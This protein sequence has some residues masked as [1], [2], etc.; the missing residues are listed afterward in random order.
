MSTSVRLSAA[1]LAD[2][3]RAHDPRISVVIATCNRADSLLRTLQMLRK[4]PERPPVIVVDNASSDGAAAKVAQSFPEVRVLALPSNIGAAARNAGCREATTPYVAFCDDDSWWSPGSLR[5]AAD[6]LDEHPRAAL[7]NAKVLVGAGADLDPTC[8]EMASSAL[9][10]RACK[11]KPIVGFLAA[12]AVVRRSAFLQAGG[13]DDRY[14][15]GGEEELLALDLAAAGWDLLYVENIVAHHHPSPAGR[16]DLLRQRR[17]LRNA[18][19]TAWLRRSLR[20]ALQHTQRLLRSARSPA[21]A[22]GALYDAL[23]GLH[24][25][26]RHRRPVPKSVESALRCLES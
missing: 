11:C 19:W 13:F 2:E 12:G 26:L 8:A 15:I 6:K 4:L 23:S 14:G 18:L 5:A 21:L 9:P 7:I 17:Q 10:A 25:V 22:R 20:G 3:Q 24:W 16:N 1:D